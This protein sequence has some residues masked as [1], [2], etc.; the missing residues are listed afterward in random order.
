MKDNQLVS[1]IIPVFNYDRYLGEAIESVLSQTYQHIEVIVVDD[2]STDRSAEV[3]KSFADRGVRY[4][5]Q[6][7]AG[8]GP[9]RNTGVELAQGEFIAFLDAD[10]RWPAEKI[11]RQLRAFE[12]DPSL[13]MCFGQAVQLH[14]GPEWEAGVK[15]NKLPEAGLVPGMVG[16]TMIIKRDAFDRVGN[17]PGG[18]KLGEFIDWYA[19]AVELQ[20][21]SVVLPD[22]FLY[23]RIHDSNQGVRERQ[24]VS[25][26]AR[27][28]KAKL[29]RNRLMGKEV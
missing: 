15:E 4:C 14:N 18:L 3:A 28:L 12:S 16:G 25:D 10:D 13:A 27:V 5:H 2:G 21:R 7:N 9:A 20:V 26:Y 17:F 8:I 23:R 22:L 11:E 6:V 1:V 29:D 24:S 19:R